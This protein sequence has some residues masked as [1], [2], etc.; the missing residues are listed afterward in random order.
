[1]P[2]VKI[3]NSKG[4]VQESGSGTKINNSLSIN[5]GATVNSTGIE[6]V[7]VSGATELPAAAGNT[8]IEFAMPA[9]ALVTDF[10]FAVT[11]AVGGGS[12]SG[13]MT[14]DLGTSAGGAEL[15]AAATVADANSTIAAGASMS[16]L[17][18]VDADASGAPFADF[19]DAAALHST[20]AR[21]LTARFTQGTGAAAGAGEVHAYVKYIILA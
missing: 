20:T 21:T 10:G 14:V 19:K 16:V 11:S 2:S 3:T 7:V 13:T 4:L 1:M 15:L 17:T 12:A 5:G 18:A 6:G 9:G 8:D